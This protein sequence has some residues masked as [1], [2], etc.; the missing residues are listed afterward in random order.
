MG[1]GKSTLLRALAGRREFRFYVLDADAAG[2]FHPS[3][4]HGEHLEDEWPAEIEILAL[5]ARIISGRGLNLITDPGELLTHREVDRFLRIMRRSRRDPSVVLLRLVV[6]PE[7]A[8]ARKTTVSARYVRAS[9]L[10][11]Q[12]APVRGEFVIQTDGLNAPAVGR[13]AAAILRKRAGV[14][15]GRPQPR[16][17]RVPRRIRRKRT[18]RPSKD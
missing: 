6:S 9:N 4:P 1:A 14:L 8:V 15:L 5:H 2:A 16:L 7:N 11:W 13:A 10:G 3:D 17:R 12:P 18:H